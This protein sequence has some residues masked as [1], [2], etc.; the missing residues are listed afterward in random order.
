MAGPRFSDGS[1]SMKRHRPR[2][3]LYCF[4]IGFACLF[5][6]LTFF[7]IRLYRDYE[8]IPGQSL[9]GNR[10]EGLKALEERGLPFAFFVM[11]DTQLSG[12]TKRMLQEASRKERPAF[13][14]VVGDFVKEPDLWRHRFFLKQVAL[15][16]SPPFPVFL[17]PGNHDI[18][19]GSKIQNPRRRVTPEVYEGLYGRRSL[20]FVFNDCL[21][22]LCGV[23]LRKPHEYLAYL[24]ETLS[25][26]GKGK[27]AIF[28]FV[29]YPP[30]GLASFIR[31]PLPKEEEFYS[32]LDAY[33]VTSCFFG[34]YHGYWR[35]QRKG[36]AFIVSGGGGRF[37]SGQPEWGRFHHILKVRVERDQVSEEI[38]V[39]RGGILFRDSFEETVFVKL[40]PLLENRVWV[41]YVLL[42][43]F[44]SWAAISVTMIFRGSK[45]K[46]ILH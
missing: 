18:D 1:E 24:R 40:L 46:G 45:R 16:L 15:D 22:I 5:C 20:D 34:D 36:V 17:V 42:G 28:V 11:G 41:L 26:K 3:T 33:G 10:V 9:L 32:L 4:S 37:K 8:R 38:M 39:F 43:L 29:H 25:L 30:Q 7:S 14:V 12:M 21:F 27:R 2:K 23:D 6:Y 31:G 35:G 19:Y 44:L 13:V